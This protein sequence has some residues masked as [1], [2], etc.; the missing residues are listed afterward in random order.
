M[1]KA[2]TL[3]VIMLL[4]CTAAAL[5]PGCVTPTPGVTQDN[6]ERLRQ[7]MTREETQRIMGRPADT[8]IVGGSS[9]SYDSLVWRDGDVSVLIR[10]WGD[11][12]QDGR[13]FVDSEPVL[14]VAE[15]N[16]FAHLI[17]L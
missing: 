11:E 2:W 3:L 4:G 15:P 1:K 13:F 17:G 9:L 10:F 14:E 16:W 7:K 6:F 12:L 5:V 8:V